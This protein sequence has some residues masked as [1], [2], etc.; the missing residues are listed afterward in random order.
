GSL[1]VNVWEST[2]MVDWKRTNGENT[3]ITINQPEA[4]MT[5]APEA[6]WDDE[7]QSY[8]VFFAS[9]LYDDA[10]HT[11]GDLYARM[12][13]V[14]TRDFVTFSSPP[15][16]WQDTGYARIDST[17]TKIGDYYYRFTKNEEG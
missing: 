4:G 14:V 6:Y 15:A 7:L 1:K 10:S 13:A 9:R 3:G 16:T 11:S 8:V 17:V 5:W 2:D 12:F